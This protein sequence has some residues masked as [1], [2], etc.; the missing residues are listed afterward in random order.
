VLFGARHFD[1]AHKKMQESWR[2]AAHSP[3][4]I[5]WE[6]LRVA[7][8]CPRNRAPARG[9]CGADHA[10][11]SGAQVHDIGHLD[12]RPL[13]KSAG[14]LRPFGAGGGGTG[15]P[16]D[17]RVE[18]RGLLPAPAAPGAEAAQRRTRLRVGQA[19]S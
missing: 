5:G 15:L 8:E 6:T 12:P 3:M 16:A 19:L 7:V 13:K 4:V 14:S 18:R 11:D 10:F 9:V 2:L 1:T 17:K